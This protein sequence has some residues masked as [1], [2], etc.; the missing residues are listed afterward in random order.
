MTV[1]TMQPAMTGANWTNF[2]FKQPCKTTVQKETCLNFLILLQFAIGIV[3]QIMLVIA[4]APLVH[5]G[6]ITK[7]N[8]SQLIEPQKLGDE[9]RRLREA[10]REAELG[11]L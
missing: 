10:R 8:K 1:L 5:Y 4:S 3:C 7:V 6:I 11:N 9:R 2:I